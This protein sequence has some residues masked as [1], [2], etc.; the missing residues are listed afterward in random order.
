MVCSSLVIVSV[1]FFRSIY[2]AT[3]G[4]KLGDMIELLVESME[5]DDD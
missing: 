2:G 3:T 1:L 5:S 4:E